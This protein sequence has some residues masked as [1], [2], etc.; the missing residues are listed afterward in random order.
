MKSILS[1][2]FLSFSL[3]SPIFA[4]GDGGEKTKWIED[5]DSFRKFRFGG[6]GEAVA[7]YHDYGQNRFTSNGS[8]DDKRAT[9]AIPRVVVAFDY[10]FTP[11]LIL[12]TEIEFEYGGTGVAKEI[13]YSDEGGEYETE[14]EKGGEVAIEQFHITKLIHPAFNIRAGHL[15]VPVGLTNAY[16]EPINFFGTVRPEG[17]TTIIPSTWH[18]NGLSLFGGFKGFEYEVMVVAGLDPNGFRRQDWI[19]NGKQGM[20]E[21]NNFTSP[22]FVARFNYRGIKGLRLGTSV[23]YNKTA[24]NASKPEKMVYK[25][26]KIS[27]PVTIVTADAQY[28]TRNFTARANMIYGMLGQSVELSAINKTLSNQSGF[29]RT[30]V[31]QNAVSYAVE[32]GYN[33]GSFFKSSKAPRIY[34]FVRYEYYNPQQK[35]EEGM[36]ADKRFQTSMWT[37]GFNYFALPNFVV[38]ADYTHRTIGGGQ[39][40]DE[41]TV[42]VGF[43]YIG[44]FV[45]K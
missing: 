27:A 23:Y 11:T 18:E 6:Y 34:P 45:K 44:W 40:N 5:Y 20:F 30:P 21:I 12:G 36:L 16:H 8:G 43:A 22:A 14:V 4:G 29:S 19:S 25:G 15:I 33:I 35:T 24:K 32:A 2:M 41:N 7:S 37:A 31:A 1:V 10:K 3:V 28:K 42:S 17:E 38:K 9:I 39:Y 26:E 13:E